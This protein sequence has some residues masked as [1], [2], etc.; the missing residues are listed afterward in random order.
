[1]AQGYRRTEDEGKDEWI[2]NVLKD[3]T[4]VENGN[5]RLV[6]LC[7]KTSSTIEEKKKRKE[8]EE[9]GGGGD[10]WTMI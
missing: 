1:M 2:N 9:G 3:I 6:V 4:T 5:V 8:E 10:G 7:G